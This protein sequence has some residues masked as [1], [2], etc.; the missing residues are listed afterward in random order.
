MID[1]RTITELATLL[2]RGYAL[3]NAATYDE[4]FGNTFFIL[5]NGA[6]NVRLVRERG[7][8]FAEIS[9]SNDPNR[10]FDLAIVFRHLGERMQ[11]PFSSLGQAAET[12]AEASSR[13]EPLFSPEVY[14]STRRRLRALEL[15]SAKERFGYSP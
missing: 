7:D 10:W 4:H 2:S 11:V 6:V 8:W 1:E 12:L 13:W 3:G 14:P 9:S 5:T 15:Q